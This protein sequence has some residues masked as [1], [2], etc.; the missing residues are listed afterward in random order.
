[1]NAKKLMQAGL[2]ATLG[3]FGSLPSLA[4]AVSC[5]D[6]LGPGGT[7]VVDQSLAC[8]SSST[9]TALTIVGLVTVDFQNHAVNCFGFPGSP[10]GNGLLNQTTEHSYTLQCNCTELSF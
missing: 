1:M 3:L 6:T 8:T 2:F 7:I 5:G 9:P 4:Y 10:P